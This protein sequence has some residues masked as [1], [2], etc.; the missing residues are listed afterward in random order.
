[1]AAMTR[2][3]MICLFYLRGGVVGVV[4]PPNE[5]TLVTHM[6]YYEIH[7]HDSIFISYKFHNIIVVSLFNYKH[8][9]FF[10]QLIWETFILSFLHL[11]GNANFGGDQLGAWGDNRI[12][13]GPVSHLPMRPEPGLCCFK[14]FHMGKYAG[15]LVFPMVRYTKSPPMC[16]ISGFQLAEH[17]SNFYVSRSV[18]QYCG[19]LALYIYLIRL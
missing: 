10:V 18:R 16:R 15:G 5:T 6:L 4:N 17:H 3:Y 7:F 9:N 19:I 14:G 8:L 2:Q 12:Y 1:M 13:V 11:I